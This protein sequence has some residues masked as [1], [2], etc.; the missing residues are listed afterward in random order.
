[1]SPPFKSPR[2]STWYGQCMAVLVATFWFVLP[3]HAQAD[4]LILRD[5][6]LLGN[7]TVI[8]FDEEGVKVTDNSMIPWHEI[9]LGTVS[10]DKQADF[11]RLRKELGDP[12]FRIHQRLKV[13]DYAGA[14]EPAET[15]FDRYKDRDS[16]VAYM[17]CQATMWGRLAEGDRAAALEPYFC[18]LRIMKKSARTSE[19]TQLPGSR[20][21]DYDKQTGLT[22]DLLPL[23]FD[24]DKAAKALPKASVAATSI[25]S[26]APD[27]VLVYMAALAIAA[28]NFSQAESWKNR[29]R[30]GNPTLKQWPVILTAQ[31]RIQT[32]DLIGARA[33]L[34]PLI[35]SFETWNQPVA[36]YLMGISGARSSE[37]LRIENG[38]LDLLHVPPLFGN[39]H[40]ELAAA[41]LAETYSALRRIQQPEQAQ[42]IRRQLLLFY[43][44]TTHAEQ[45]RQA[46]QSNSN[47]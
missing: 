43:G 4:R 45:I 33:D 25:G 42:D 28:E 10:P 29:I 1:M 6:R 20:S 9:E 12:L 16:K 37:F 8:G 35:Y 36:W 3:A 11:D 30:S 31:S 39:D 40:P 5:L 44:G 27:G 38:V 19:V 21:L 15:I 46:T 34:E 41:A 18:C 2:A 32:G 14:R 26:G 23:F 24:R 7:I 13:G 47:P 22:S 17:V